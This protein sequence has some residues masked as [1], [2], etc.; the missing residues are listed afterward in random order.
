[1]N[2][3]ATSTA[4][5]SMPARP[6]TR[7]RASRAGLVG[8]RAPSSTRIVHLGIGNFH[9]AHQAQYSAA[10]MASGDESWGVLGV[11]RSSAQTVTALLRQDL[12][13]SVV[14]VSS[15]RNQISVPAVHTGAIVAAGDSAGVVRAMAGAKTDIVTLTVTERGYTID[16]RTGGLAKSDPQ[17]QRDLGEPD[18]PTTTI[19]KL[20]RTFQQRART[21]ASPLTVISCD[22]LLANGT[23]TALL[24]QEFISELPER[25]ARPIAEYVES[26]V[27]FPN[28]MVDRIVPATTAR[29]RDIV[30]NQTGIDDAVPVPAE[31]FSMWVIENFD[32]PR[33]AW[34]RGGALFTGDV[35]P[36]E[37]AKLRLLNGTHSL[38]AYLGALSNHRT[39]PEAVDD[40][41]IAAVALRAIWADYVPSLPQSELDLPA[42]V[43]SLFVRWR[44]HALGHKTSQ[45]ASDGSLKLPQRVPGPALQH[46]SSGRMPHT[47]ALT[48]AAY[49]CCLAP[50][51]GTPATAAS[52]DIEDP[53]RADFVRRAADDPRGW[54]RTVLRDGILGTDIAAQQDFHGRVDELYRLLGAHGVQAALKEVD[55]A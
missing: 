54:V 35:R 10:A 33:P 46:L 26:S 15:Q 18:D 30:R 29:I 48:V 44:N 7:A 49:L 36:Y 16:A 21:H 1:M 43:D 17:V 51:D 38:L 40:E 41:G 31:P 2:L 3:P 23:A 8:G 53:A 50:P 11:T 4:P 20:V 5:D 25:E 32:G 52:R 14:E 19:G 13:Y 34:E 28:S 42:Y 37:L 47:L 24:V 6:L 22:N 55:A 27:R 12:L 9:R 39:I 45:V